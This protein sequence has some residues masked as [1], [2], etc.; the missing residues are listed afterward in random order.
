MENWH[1]PSEK[2]SALE[3]DQVAKTPV[4]PGA[5][6]QVGESPTRL[7]PMDQPSSVDLDP[8]DSNGQPRPLISRLDPAHWQ[9]GLTIML[10]HT[11]SK[12]NKTQ[13]TVSSPGHEKGKFKRSLHR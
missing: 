2:K 11:S 3:G 5:T 1:L 9:L 6:P 12:A 10:V 13:K 8:D 7:Y 4:A